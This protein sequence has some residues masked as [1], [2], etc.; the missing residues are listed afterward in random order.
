MVS[1]C[2][3]YVPTPPP[4]QAT[5][6]SESES[7]FWIGRLGAVAGS[8][9]GTTASACAFP[10]PSTSPS[11]A[12][13]TAGRPAA[14]SGTRWTR[15][16]SRSRMIIILVL[17]PLLGHCCSPLLAAACCCCGAVAADAL[18]SKWPS[19]RCHG[20]DALAAVGWAMVGVQHPGAAAAAAGPLLL[21]AVVIV[22]VVPSLWHSCCGRQRAAV[23]VA[24]IALPQ[25]CAV[26]RRRS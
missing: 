17:R 7:E 22:A 1:S 20:D 9:P 18:P 25:R 6:E 12:P 15:R 16:Q 21:A 19:T 26:A 14:G 3:A 24:V 11:W 2:T 13:S 23:T 10:R 4:L 8:E 5:S